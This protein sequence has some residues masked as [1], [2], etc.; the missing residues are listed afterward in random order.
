MNR[1]RGCD[2]GFLEA[3]GEMGQRIR[4]FDWSATPLGPIDSWSAPFLASLR[5]MLLTR[6]PMYIA[7]GPA[8]T[9]VYNDAY[10]ATIPE[11]HPRALGMS[12][13]EVWDETSWSI[14]APE[15]EAAL[16]GRS[17]FVRNR[18]HPLG[19]ADADADSYYTFCSVP[20][21]DEAG[22]VRGVFCSGYETTAEVLS[23]ESYR[24]ES[25]RLRSLFD[26]APGFIGVL[27]GA[28]HRFEIA[29]DALQALVG[30]RD[31]IGRPVRL[32]LPELEGQGYFE[33]LDEVYRTGRSHIAT[34]V[35]VTLRRTL[36][37]PEEQRI[38]T[39]IYQPI[40]DVA[41]VVTGIF[42]EGS[43]V[44]E[45]VR[46]D[47]RRKE[48]ERLA[49]ST[50]DALGEHIAVID[51][52]GTI[53]AANAAWREF[54]AKGGAAPASVSEGAN[55][56]TACDRA[57][58]HGD[59]VAQEVGALIRRVACGSAPSAELEY[60]CPTPEGLLWFNLRISRFRDE[61]PTRIVVAHED[62]TARRANEERIEHLATH[63]ALTGLPNR[64]LLESRAQK[65]IEECRERGSEMAVLFLDLDNFRH[66]NDAYGHTT[67]D[68]VLLGVASELGTLVGPEDTIG[69]LG[70]DELVVLLPALPGA[71]SEAEKIAKAITG[72]LASPMT[73]AS[74]ELATTASIGIS[75]YPR[76]GETFSELLKN[77]DAALSQAK[78]SG[79]GGYRF[80]NAEMA[81]ELRD[82]ARLQTELRKAL[83]RGQMTIVYQPKVSMPDLKTIGLEALLRWHHPELGDIAP[84]RFIPIAEEAGLIG[85]IGTFAI[86]MSCSQAK[87]WQ[88]AGLPRVPVAVNVSAAQLAHP[89]F[90]DTVIDALWETGLDPAF[91]ELEITEGIMVQKG[92]VLTRR[93]DALRAIGVELTIDDFGTGYS[94]LAYLKA[95]PISRL[96]IDR[97]FVQ[98]L[99]VDPNALS[100]AQAV[101]AL[102]RS[103]GL[104]VLAEGVETEE[105]ASI[106]VEMGC[107]EAQG[108]LYSR[109][110]TP[111][112]IERWF[113][114][115]AQPDLRREAR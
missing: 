102:G 86:R 29:N 6:L 41:G 18:P 83:G 17:T 11:R 115:H 65:T 99:G 42:V 52:E 97:I 85:E 19:A 13:R 93:L 72:R 67:G 1:D 49:R 71:P 90:I 112:G 63:D 55:Y 46:A 113:A 40:R 61:G 51:E 21:S 33:L 74:R 58:D 114:D 70:G 94:N 95:F 106:L 81:V 12:L 23:H 108:F 4:A 87:S 104:R 82:R 64:R 111:D 10:A 7:W 36:D 32:A 26:Q 38:V 100:I 57:A 43:D 2:L 110:L 37:S 60:A 68:E 75:I 53:L 109:P 9:L 66:V 91:L 98:E 20:L 5:V 22:R 69:R 54:A 47:A 8:L 35:P 44:T 24:A 105:Q 79:R 96:K 89:D 103:L 30:R 107:E 25:E 50:M 78:G 31:L 76:D 48:S 77:A 88:R 84:D 56:L 15:I 45:A 80:Y 92:D 59:S 62:I 101:F 28:D 39:F 73:I 14:I 34:G 3:N 16:A 27:K